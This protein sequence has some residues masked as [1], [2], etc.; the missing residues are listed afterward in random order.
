MHNAIA[1]KSYQYKFA[2]RRHDTLG[3]LQKFYC[4]Q[5]LWHTAPAEAVMYNEVEEFRGGA[6][7][8]CVLGLLLRRASLNPGARV[9]KEDVVLAG[10]GKTEVGARS[11]VYFRVN[12]NDS[13]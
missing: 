8:K 3:L 13:C 12:L 5:M 2:F 4:V 1:I 10:I 11:A 7:A 6:I 9:F